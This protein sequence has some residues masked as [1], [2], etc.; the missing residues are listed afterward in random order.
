MEK[1]QHK[2]EKQP[3]APQTSHAIWHGNEPSRGAKVDDSLG[4]DDEQ[5]L[6]KKGLA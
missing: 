4:E 3:D 5:A 2:Q 6:K 1:E